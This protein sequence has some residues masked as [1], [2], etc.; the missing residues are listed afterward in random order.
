MTTKITNFTE[1]NV[2]SLQAEL[3]DTL[4]EL[5]K[6]YGINITPVGNFRYSTNTFTTKI[7]GSAMADTFTMIKLGGNISLK[8]AEQ[9]ERLGLNV[10]AGN[11][12]LV[13]YRPRNRKYPFIYHQNGQHYKCSEAEAKRIFSA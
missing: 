13:D 6:K 4:N 9:I 7:E 10:S 8:L 1:A 3:K 11:M 12:Q 5:G 2:R